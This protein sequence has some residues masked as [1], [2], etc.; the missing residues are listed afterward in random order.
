MDSTEIHLV[1]C[2]TG[3]EYD[4]ISNSANP[5]YITRGPTYRTLV[6]SLAWRVLQ[7]FNNVER[8]DDSANHEDDLRFPTDHHDDWADDQM[9]DSVFQLMRQIYRD[10]VYSWIET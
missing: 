6:I 10:R 2:G 4:G 3:T 1:S 9:E 8:I 7:P 5:R